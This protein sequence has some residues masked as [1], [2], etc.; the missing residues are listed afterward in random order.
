MPRERHGRRL[1]WKFFR[2]VEENAFT[3]SVRL[4]EYDA[5]FGV[6]VQV[7]STVPVMFNYWTPAADGLKISQLLNDHIASA[8]FVRRLRVLSVSGLCPCKRLSWQ[9]LKRNVAFAN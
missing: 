2:R 8:L 3:P 7:L 9:S 5:Q 4:N 6:R 1:R